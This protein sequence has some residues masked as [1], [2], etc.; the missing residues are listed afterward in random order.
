MVVAVA[1]LH[2]GPCLGLLATKVGQH[3]T[4]NVAFC[5]VLY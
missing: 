2:Q 5:R 1:E 4:D 3:I